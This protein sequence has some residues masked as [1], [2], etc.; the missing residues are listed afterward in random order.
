[1]AKEKDKSKEKRKKNYDDLPKVLEGPVK[2]QPLSMR[3]DY[4]KGQVGPQ[5]ATMVKQIPVE[6]LENKLKPTNYDEPCPCQA[7]GGPELQEELVKEM[8]PEMGMM[9][10]LICPDCGTEGP[11]NMEPPAGIPLE[12][13]KLKCAKCSTKISFKG[14]VKTASGKY[15]LAGSNSI[16][17]L[18]DRIRGI[19]RQGEIITWDLANDVSTTLDQICKMVGKD[20][21]KD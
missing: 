13:R 17:A 12:T 18:T 5:D 4:G 2:G 21:S 15:I 14:L 10:I 9:T 8:S 20:K 19:V 1:M 16:K 11:F 3:P 7:P 6:D